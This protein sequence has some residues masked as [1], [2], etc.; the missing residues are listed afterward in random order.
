MY[1]YLLSAILLLVIYSGC[2]ENAQIHNPINKNDQTPDP[3]SNVQVESLPGGVK[4]SYSLP[5]SD[6]ILYAKAVYAI[7][8]G[9]ESDIKS[10][11]YN[12]SLTIEGF[13]DT[14]EHTV[15]LYT[16]TRGGKA[17]EPVITKIKPL[18]PPVIKTFQSL[19]A[20][21]TFGGVNVS[22]QNQNEAD[23]AITVLTTD[24]LGNLYPADVNYTKDIKGSFSARGF[25]PENR[26]F[27]IFVK[28]RW[29]N[30]SDTLFTEITPYFEEELDKTKFK[31]I[32]LPTDTYLTYDG[33]PITLM[34][35]D[36]WGSLNNLF[37]THPGTGMPQWY[38]IDLGVKATL[39]RFLLY[40]RK[41][42]GT[43][44]GFYAGDPKEV[45]VWGSNNPNTDGTWDSWTFLGNFKC[46]E[47][48]GPDG[49]PTAEDFQKASID[50]ENFDFSAGIP[51]VRYLR[52]KVVDTWGGTSYMWIAELTFW[53]SIQ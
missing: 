51:A 46:L 38:T 28:D 9:E 30:H 11:Y 43:A 22:F 39:S 52:F 42:N 10:S 49:K 33:Y 21:P 25:A 47:P 50:G 34:W 48:S 37:A 35:D 12:N 31:Q 1:K 17:S 7:R 26:K 5:K 29:N 32:I 16:V 41:Q 13:A 2:K 40:H 15:K 36:S 45:E 20:V 14:L 23:L 4:I 8:K 3:V 6:D 24:S 19:V 53:G 27:G 18:L 44:G